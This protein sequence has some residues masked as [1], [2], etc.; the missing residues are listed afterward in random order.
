MKQTITGNSF[1]SNHQI[2]LSATTN[3]LRI[4]K[5]MPKLT[6]VFTES[7]GTSIFYFDFQLCYNYENH[8]SYEVGS[9][10]RRHW[11]IQAT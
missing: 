6:F 11:S 7:Q 3:S 1:V 4:F 5:G 2:K 9:T 10:Y 8:L